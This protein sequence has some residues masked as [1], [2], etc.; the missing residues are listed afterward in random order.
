VFEIDRYIG[1]GTPADYELYQKTFE[2]WNGFY[3][4]EMQRMTGD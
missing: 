4:R 3:K 1:W 2:Y